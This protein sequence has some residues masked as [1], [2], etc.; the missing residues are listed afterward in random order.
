MSLAEWPEND[1]RIFVGDLCN[2]V[3]DSTLAKV[4][5]KYSSFAK[6]KVIRDKRTQKSRGYGFVSFLDPFDA[7][8]AIKEMNG[9]KRT[10]LDQ[11][12][13]T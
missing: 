12:N 10:T 6:A 7:G 8:E 3:N 5:V 13:L 4:F 1:Y 9:T 11:A 2:D